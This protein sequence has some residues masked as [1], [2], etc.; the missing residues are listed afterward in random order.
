MVSERWANGAYTWFPKLLQLQNLCGVVMWSTFGSFTA[1][2]HNSWRSPWIS[3]TC[4]PPPSVSA[5]WGWSRDM[6]SSTVSDACHWHQ[7]VGGGMKRRQPFALQRLRLGR[8]QTG[9]DLDQGGSSPSDQWYLLTGSAGFI[10][11]KWC[12]YMTLCIIAKSFSNR[13]S[14]PNYH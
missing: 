12:N 3:P 1:D 2:P 7:G 8:D 4:L 5:L 11:A 13:N 10:V 14:I 9:N 6:G